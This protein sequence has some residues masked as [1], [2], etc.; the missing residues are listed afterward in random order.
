MS[1]SSER[2]GRARNSALGGESPGG[3]DDSR[4]GVIH[5]ALEEQP[6]RSNVIEA[7]FMPWNEA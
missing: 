1:Q 2:A 7:R 6:R 5:V 4:A 3:R